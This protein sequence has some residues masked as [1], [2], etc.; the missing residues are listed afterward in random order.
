[1]TGRRGRNHSGEFKVKAALAVRGGLKDGKT[2][3][4][5]PDQFEAHPNP[6]KKPSA[7]EKIDG[8]ICLNSVG[9]ILC[10]GISG[11]GWVSW[12]NQLAVTV[13]LQSILHA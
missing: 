11:R 6:I 5:L 1:M 10:R 9:L 4:G 3:S 2:I 12:C 7:G 8:Q 13:P